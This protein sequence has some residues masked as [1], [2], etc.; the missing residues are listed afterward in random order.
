MAIKEIPLDRLPSVDELNVGGAMPSNGNSA[1][2][3]TGGWRTQRPA[4]DPSLC[5][6]CLICWISCPDSSIMLDEGKVIG[7]DEMHCKG[8]GICA[9]ECPTKEPKALVMLQGGFYQGN[10]MFDRRK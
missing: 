7:I 2:Y 4:F 10:E 9:K 3:A 1:L 5:T 6:N 8:C